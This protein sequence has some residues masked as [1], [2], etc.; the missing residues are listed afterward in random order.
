MDIYDIATNVWSIGAFSSVVSP[1]AHPYNGKIYCVGY[2]GMKIYTIATNTWSMVANMPTERVALTTCICNDKIFCIGGC[3]LGTNDGT[4]Y[5]NIVE[6]YDITKG[7]WTTSTPMPVSLA[8][9]ASVSFNGKIFCIGGMGTV[10]AI[11]DD[12]TSFGQDIYIKINI[13][14]AD[15]K[16]VR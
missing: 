8:G 10:E 14:I 5:Y 2:P 11:L 3:G 9:L 6:V 4:T 15:W 12:G 7:I 13:C 1:I 16:S